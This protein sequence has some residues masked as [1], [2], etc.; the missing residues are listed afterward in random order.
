MAPKFKM[1]AK[2]VFDLAFTNMQFVL[3]FSEYCEWTSGHLLKTSKF[4]LISHFSDIYY[5]YFFQLFE[6]QCP[7]ML[8]TIRNTYSESPL[9]A[10]QLNV[11]MLPSP[12]T[13][14]VIFEVSLK[15][16]NIPKIPQ[17]KIKQSIFS[18]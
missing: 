3:K 14:A 1:A 7:V 12:N 5:N 16:E 9:S 6:T 2:I 18:I 11:K 15:K 4:R 10:L 13:N 17:N 8:Y